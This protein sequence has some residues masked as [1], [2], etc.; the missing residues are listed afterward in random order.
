MKKRK[1]LA[2]ALAMSLIFTSMSFADDTIAGRQTAAEDSLEQEYENAEGESSFEEW[3]EAFPEGE[4][5]PADGLPTE[6]E[7]SSEDE[8]QLEKS[9]SED[10]QPS[11]EEPT[12]EE[13]LPS[14]D[15]I[16]PEEARDEDETAEDS[17]IQ[18]M[19]GKK[20]ESDILNAASVSDKQG[21]RP[22][23][24]FVKN[25]SGYKITLEADEGVLPADTTASI[26]MIEEINGKAIKEIVKEYLEDD[27]AIDQFVSFDITLYSDGEEIE[28]DNGTVDMT[29]Q[30]AGRFKKIVEADEAELKVFHVKSADDIDEISAEMNENQEVVCEVSGFSVYTIGILNAVSADGQKIIYAGTVEEF[31][32]SLQSNTKIVLEG[33]T[34]NT[35][36]V[37]SYDWDDDGIIDNTNDVSELYLQG[38]ENLTIQGETGTRIVSSSGSD[39]IFDLSD[40][41]NIV[42]DNLIIGHDIPQ[43]PRYGC[44]IDVG[45]ILL[46]DSD[47]KINNCDIF[48]CGWFGI[49]SHGSSIEAADT[50]IRDCSSHIL[51]INWNSGICRFK[52]CQF[53]GNGYAK[54]F[55]TAI[56]YNGE[57]D[58]LIFENCTFKNNSN[59][60]FCGTVDSYWE[61]DSEGNEELIVLGE[62][63]FFTPKII[64][65][66]FSNN[67]WQTDHII[68]L[69]LDFQGLK[70]KQMI[71][72]TTE[73]KLSTINKS[74]FT[75]IPGYLFDGWY[76]DQARTEK[77][78]LSAYQLT[79]DVTFYGKWKKQSNSG[80]SSGGNSG[81][82][83]GGSSKKDSRDDSGSNQTVSELEKYRKEIIAQ[84]NNSASNT[85]GGYTLAAVFADDVSK[86]NAFEYSLKH[87]KDTF[88]AVAGGIG[89]L[90]S[91]D[92][93]SWSDFENA[94]AKE[95]M[96]NE[97]ANKEFLAD[98]INN[99]FGTNTSSS[100]KE[101]EK[102]I[103]Y[104][105]AGISIEKELEKFWEDVMGEAENINPTAGQYT[106]VLLGYIS[107]AESSYKEFEKMF[108]DY[109]ENKR[110]L[111]SIKSVVPAGSTLDKAIDDLIYQYET[112]AIRSCANVAINVLNQ[113]YTW[114]SLQD[115]SKSASLT[116][117]L[118]SQ[119]NSDN[120]L[121]L[122]S[123][124]KLDINAD[125]ILDGNLNS[126]LQKAGKTIADITVGTKF[127]LVDKVL[128]VYFADNKEVSAIDKVVYSTYIRSN[129]ITAL[130]QAEEKIKAPGAT[131]EDLVAYMNAFELAR[132]VTQV[133]YENMHTI[134]FQYAKESKDEERLE[135]LV[136]AAYAQSSIDRLQKMAAFDSANY[137]AE[138]YSDFKESALNRLY[139]TQQ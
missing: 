102:N 3:K 41:H 82:G 33:K 50:K 138:N 40:C 23:F 29:I 81:S 103:K 8:Q 6:W 10:E 12:S 135:Y 115:G 60:N 59:P 42:F 58:N 73:Y 21:E 122:S 80:N 61:T 100:L 48:G 19:N 97:A 123:W 15:E 63:A 92:V 4:A 79:K 31:M 25:I 28:P 85:I 74:E 70:E 45:V 13:G 49:R 114:T 18:Q 120:P 94:M 111:Q 78:D 71:P 17:G 68:H 38:I 52:N 89:A 134:Y 121:S 54:P 129:A 87:W 88:G 118:G 37:E 62:A 84:G 96:T 64:N 53:Y 107:S 66:T 127:D 47:V 46:Y 1:I 104:G 69:T 93:S 133:Q 90:F 20:T 35:S 86:F 105:S 34:Y 132:S 77:I 55:L 56:Q 16:H 75:S 30:L 32:A 91:G 67:E 131:E 109:S 43:K 24:R 14:E 51:D 108:M 126:I 98:V 99:I 26:K 110:M 113:S 22:A 124:K 101:L 72:A 57:P 44:D 11:E 125:D 2:V 7:L 76:L 39:V 112:Q 65:C 9:S 130:R 27:Q 119:L 83:S 36:R 106:G 137:G 139:G 117:I 128:N 116:E 136:K 5:L 95:F